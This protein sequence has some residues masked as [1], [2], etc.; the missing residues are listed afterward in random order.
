MTYLEGNYEIARNESINSSPSSPLPS[1]YRNEK[2]GK[3][4]GQEGRRR[5]MGNLSDFNPHN[6]NETSYELSSL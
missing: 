5:D 1:L 3:E 2:R 6:E 4:R